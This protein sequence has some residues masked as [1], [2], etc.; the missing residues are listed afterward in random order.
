M[1]LSLYII[2]LEIYL[3]RSIIFNNLFDLLNFA[4]FLIV[5]LIN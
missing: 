1:I 4:I 3:M 2:F 5:D